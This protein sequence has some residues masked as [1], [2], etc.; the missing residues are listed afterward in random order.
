MSTFS[1]KVHNFT[2]EF[3]AP[4]VVIVTVNHLYVSKNVY[5]IKPENN[6]LNTWIEVNV[7][8]HASVNITPFWITNNIFFFIEIFLAQNLNPQ[9]TW[10]TGLLKKHIT[11]KCSKIYRAYHCHLF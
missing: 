11:F 7:I 5:S 9:L 10:D 4:P 1:L 2:D 6:V 3:Y 8:T